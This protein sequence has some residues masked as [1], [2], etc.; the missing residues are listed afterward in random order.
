MKTKHTNTNDRRNRRGWKAT[1]A[2]V[3]GALTLTMLVASPAH[4]ETGYDLRMINNNAGHVLNFTRTT[5]T[6]IKDPGTQPTVEPGETQTIT[7]RDDNNIFDECDDQEKNVGWRVAV[8]SVPAPDPLGFGMKWRIYTP[9]WRQWYYKVD[10]LDGQSVPATAVR[11]GQDDANHDCM[12]KEQW[13]DRDNDNGMFFHFDYTGMNPQPEG[14]IMVGDA[15]TL[16]GIG[17]QGYTVTLH[18]G[19]ATGPTIPGCENLAVD[20]SGTAVGGTS[21]GGAW[22][23]SSTRLPVG[24]SLVV[25]VQNDGI[26]SS[27]QTTYT[28]LSPATT[29]IPETLNTAQAAMPVTGKATPGATVTTT[30]SSK[31]DGAPIMH[32]CTTTAGADGTWSCPSYDTAV[33]GAYKWRIDQNLNDRVAEPIFSGTRVTAATPVSINSPAKDGEVIPEWVPEAQINGHGQV[34]LNITT[35]IVD[36]VGTQLPLIS[37][38]CINGTTTVNDNDRWGCGFA[39]QGRPGTWHATAT[40]HRTD[41][42]VLGTPATRTFTIVPT[43]RIRMNAPTETLITGTAAPGT[44]I[45]VTDPGNPGTPVCTTTAPGGPDL[46]APTPWSCDTTPQTTGA[47]ATNYTATQTLNGYTDPLTAQ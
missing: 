12:N 21:A 6:C 40:E 17:A 8:G 39:P 9:P 27:A 20:D 7:I 1:A 42:S 24:V 31:P 25:A 29:T 35:Q 32:A 22:S 34:G 19:S 18:Q 30:L 3:I 5:Q 43:A 37:P 26:A 10:G 45:T 14:A 46:T 13:V 33:P 38:S 41:G 11:C 23:C 44:T 47:Q 16:S 15:E 36:S 2:G 4:A 28:V